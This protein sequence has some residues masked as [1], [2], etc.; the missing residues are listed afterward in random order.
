MVNLMKINW[1]MFTK[2]CFKLKK[3]LKDKRIRIKR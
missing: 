1:S 2:D 3:K